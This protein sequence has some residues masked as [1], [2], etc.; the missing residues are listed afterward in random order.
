MTLERDSL[1]DALAAAEVPALPERLAARALA[2]ATAH[3]GREPQCRTTALPFA[4]P[5][6][7]FAVPALLGAAAVA[8]AI[9][10]C[11]RVASIFGAS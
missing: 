2:R 5:A 6:P 1:L 10:T 3:L 11:L 9:D 4:L 8:V 7:G